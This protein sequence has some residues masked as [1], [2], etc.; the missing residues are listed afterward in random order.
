MKRSKVMTVLKLKD[1]VRY[2]FPEVKD[3]FYFYDKKIES[4][5][6]LVTAGATV[7]YKEPGEG[8]LYQF[9]INVTAD[10]PA[11][12]VDDVWKDL[13]RRFA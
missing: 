8:P 6:V 3:M 10:S 1:V 9:K 5:Y 12:L 13:K 7:N 4:E 11:A 2:V